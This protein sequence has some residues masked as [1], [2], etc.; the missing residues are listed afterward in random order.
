MTGVDAT[1][2]LL[3]R[4]AIVQAELRHISLENVPLSA[5]MI[6][7]TSESLSSSPPF[8]DTEILEESVATSEIFRHCALIYLFRVMRGDSVPLDNPTQESVDEVLIP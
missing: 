2:E 5:I 7:T 3:S 1:A 8:I 6:C 4:G